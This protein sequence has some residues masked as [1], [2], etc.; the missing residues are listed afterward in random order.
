MTKVLGFD[1]GGTK[2]EAGLL[3]ETGR[4]WRTLREPTPARREDL[5][6]TVVTMAEALGRGVAVAAVGFAIPGSLDPRTG[7]LRNA[8]NSPQ[9]NETPFGCDL[10]ERI[11]RPLFFDNDANCLVRSEVRFGIARGYDHVVG[12]IM[13]TGLGAGVLSGGRMIQG[14]R[15][16]A[17][18]P[19]HTVLHHH[20]RAC[21]CGNRGCAEAYLSGTS[22]YAR[23]REAGGQPLA[24]KAKDVFARRETNPIAG[25]VVEET[26]DLFARFTAGL[27]ALYDPALIVLGGGVSEQVTYYRQESAI[28][29][30]AF[31]T[32][33]VPPIRAAGLG[34]TSGKL[35]AAA[36][37]LDGSAPVSSAGSDPS[38]GRF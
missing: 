31:G 38:A 30:Y 34:P 18:E 17:P 9:I 3:D 22:I 27:I 1:I 32:D 36:L 19:G 11:N 14:W 5:L 21:L 20:G 25:V 16:L 6:Q 35:G 37:A 23:Y 29:A 7:L 26:L 33:E 8:P 15:G 24:G 2:I 4:E 28:A 12:I 13:G 10:R